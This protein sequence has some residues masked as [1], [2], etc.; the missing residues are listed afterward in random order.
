MFCILDWKTQEQQDEE[1]LHGLW[2]SF[3][4][5]PHHGHQQPARYS[6]LNQQTLGEKS[7]RGAKLTQ[8]GKQAKKK[9]LH[10]D[11]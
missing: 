6:Q 7:I 10:Q 3:P 11:S 8:S 2:S 5:H 9:Q 1:T 4:P